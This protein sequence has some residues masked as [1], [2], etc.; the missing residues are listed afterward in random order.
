M[1]TEKWKMLR[2]DY[3]I[4][5]KQKENDDL[6]SAFDKAL[7]HLQQQH[8]FQK[9]LAQYEFGDQVSI[10]NMIQ[11]Y[12]VGTDSLSILRKAVD[13]LQAQLNYNLYRRG[14]HDISKLSLCV[15]LLLVNHFTLGLEAVLFDDNEFDIDSDKDLERTYFYLGLFDRASY[16]LIPLRAKMLTLIGNRI[17]AYIRSYSSQLIDVQIYANE[18]IFSRDKNYSVFL[19]AMVRIVLDTLFSG[20]PFHDDDHDHHGDAIDP[21]AEDYSILRV[22]GKQARGHYQVVYAILAKCLKENVFNKYK[23]TITKTNTSQYIPVNVRKYVLEIGNHAFLHALLEDT[24]SGWIVVKKRDTVGTLPLSAYLPYTGEKAIE[25]WYDG[26][27]S[28]TDYYTD[29]RDFFYENSGIIPNL[30]NINTDVF[31]LIQGVVEASRDDGIGGYFEPESLCALYFDP[32]L[33]VLNSGRIKPRY[34]T[35]CE[36]LCKSLEADKR[37]LN[38]S[39]AIGIKDKSN[40][41]RP[42]GQIVGST[43]NWT[44]GVVMG[45]R[46]NRGQYLNLYTTTGEMEVVIE[47][48]E[49]ILGIE[50][51]LQS[52]HEIFLHILEVGGIDELGFRYFDSFE[53]LNETTS[54]VPGKVEDIVNLDQLSIS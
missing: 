16:K 36:I 7:L 41:I 15:N 50:Y 38:W 34:K 39:Q 22:Y 46:G 5:E 11:A 37:K 19:N 25:E 21:T 43:Y 30:M 13:S 18:I 33:S 51:L 12:G 6:I 45:D 10:N 40:G 42:V 52:E 3:G 8:E 1:E 27:E 20:N 4:E 24:T 14:R 35:A 29:D 54:L 48:S 53:V 49:S 28:Y 31:R 9:Q 23:I 2:T 32:L 17:S 26:R 44:V 47:N